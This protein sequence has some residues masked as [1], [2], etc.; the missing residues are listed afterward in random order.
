MNAKTFEVRDR[1]TFI[2]VLAVQ[3]EPGG[4]QDRYLLGRAGFGTSAGVQRRY[5][6]VTRIGGGA[7]TEYNPD[8]WGGRTMPTAHQHIID[9]FDE[10]P[11]G[12]VVDVRV[13]LGEEEFPVQSERE[14][15]VFST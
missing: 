12:S 3:L 7:Q 6:L 8:L 11:S 14:T 4:E 10:L 13:V 2:P 9:H 5:V 15:E 1:M